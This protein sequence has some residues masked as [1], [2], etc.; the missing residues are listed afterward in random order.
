MSRFITTGK[1]ICAVARNFSD[2]AKELGNA[3][4]EKP[5][6][7]LKPTSSYAQEGSPIVIPP[8]AASLHHEVELGVV[9]GKPGSRINARNAMDHVEGYVLALD[10]T[11]R[12]IQEEAKAQKRPWTE[13]KGYD[14]FCPVGDFIPKDM[15]K[16][17][18]NVNLWL[19]V[20]GEM[21][22]NGNTKDMIFKIP[23]LIEFVT[24]IMKLEEGDVILTGTPAGVGPV[25]AGDEIKAGIDGVT[26]VKFSVVKR[27]D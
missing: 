24:D 13:A 19:S 10:M 3:V 5:F 17:P 25:V 15:I 12:D 6:M 21:K 2:H 27:N 8:R 7:F 4:P 23:E 26:E 16:D 9:M 1:K 14:S 20:N 22:Q 18:H 11:A